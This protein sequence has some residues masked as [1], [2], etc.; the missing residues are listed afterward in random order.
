[1]VLVACSDRIQEHLGKNVAV[2]YSQCFVILMENYQPWY[3]FRFLLGHLH[4]PGEI[5][6][7]VCKFFSFFFFFWGGGGGG[8]Q[9]ILWDLRK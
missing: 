3:C 7:N 4:V 6:N 5:A 8:K 9:D 1:M 2:L